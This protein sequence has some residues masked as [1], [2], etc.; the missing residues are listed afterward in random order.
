MEGFLEA[1][2]NPVRPVRAKYVVRID[3]KGV[4]AVDFSETGP[5]ELLARFKEGR[6]QASLWLKK[7]V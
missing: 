2:R 3:P 6:R 7:N 1:V 5:D 4:E